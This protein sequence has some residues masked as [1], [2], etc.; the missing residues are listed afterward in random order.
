MPHTKTDDIAVQL[1]IDMLRLRHG[2]DF[3]HYARASLRRRVMGLCR[4]LQVE[5]AADL[6]PLVLH[7]DSLLPRVLAGLSVPVTEMFRDPEVFLYL[8]REILPLLKSFPRIN[9]WQVG[10]AT[11]EEAYSLAILLQEEDVY[12]R[13]RIFST[14]IND[15]ALAQAEEGIFPAERIKEYSRNYFKAGGTR[16][17]SDYYHAQYDL[18]K[19]DE[20]LKANILFTH[21]NVVSDGV[22]GEMQLILCRN[23]LIYFDR[24]LQARVQKLFCDSLVRGGILCLGMKESLAPRIDNEFRA[25]DARLKIFRRLPKGVA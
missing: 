21:H 14:D 18:V 20:S 22:F 3:R 8:R 6:I 12:H 23:V 1:F 15:S 7:D 5:R 4:Q 16:S 9:I 19:M 13:A 10:C 25:L 2:Y 11:G 17:L 24:E